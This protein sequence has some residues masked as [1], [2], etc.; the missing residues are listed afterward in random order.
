M[1][2]AGEV[3]IPLLVVKAVRAVSSDLVH[4]LV[5][6]PAAVTTSAFLSV[7]GTASE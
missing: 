2:P 5:G 3:C 6:L 4:Y 1:L 7:S